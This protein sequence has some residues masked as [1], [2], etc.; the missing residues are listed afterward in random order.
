M[1][2]VLLSGPA[3]GGKSQLARELLRQSNE[4]TVAA[5][6]QAIVA[7]LLL[8]ERGPDGKYP[9]R[10]DYVLPLAEYVR[11]SIISGAKTRE[12]NTVT[13]NSDG[14]PARRS[15]L[16]GLLGSG[17]TETIIDPGQAVVVARLSDTV[18]GELSDDCTQ[19]I[20]RW[21]SRIGRS[22]RG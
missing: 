5:D 4:P 15:Y 22:N 7:A 12:L 8:Q 16:L 14:D 1:P 9:L 19:A 11:Q 17:A 21:Y 20:G 18:S 10:P 2:N 6:F 3:G 13:T